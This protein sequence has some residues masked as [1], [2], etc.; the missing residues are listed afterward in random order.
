VSIRTST[1]RRGRSLELTTRLLQRLRL[2]HPTAGLWE[3]ADVQWWSRIPRSSDDLDQMFWLDAAGDP[4]AAVVLTDWSGSW[5]CDPI[6]IPSVGEELLPTL[7]SHALRRVADLELSDVEVVVRD[8][9]A[10]LVELVSEAGWVTTP[11]RGAACWLDAAACAPI[12][13]L[14]PAYRVLDR[15]M[16]GGRPHHFIPRSGP[17][18]AERLAR[19]SLYRP[20]LD[21][22]AVT[23]DGAVAGYGLFWHDPVTGVG[24]VE[25]MRTE[26]GHEG[27]GIAGHLLT[28]GLDRLAGL[29]ATRLKVNVDPGNTRA[30]RL[31]GG[32]GFEI[33]STARVFIRRTP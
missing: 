4:V 15:K 20:D 29:G 25:P 14:A 27:R 1:A 33:E 16:A 19:T 30:V 2:E 26:K 22:F 18:V 11:G 9:D 24:L 3:A 7:W 5:G 13:D 17:D 8:D 23:A 12:T 32:A 28:A 21:L 10:R 31:Y 6:V